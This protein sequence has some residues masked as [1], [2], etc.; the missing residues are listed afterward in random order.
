VLLQNLKFVA[1]RKHRSRGSS[2][3]IATGYGLDCW[4]SGVKFPARVQN[5][6]VTHLASYPIGT[7]ALSPRVKWLG[8]EVDHSPLS[9]AEVKNAWRYI[10]TPNTSSGRGA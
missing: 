10:S 4:G 8:R 3:G 6:S 2:D 5:G 7:G 1:H 9:S